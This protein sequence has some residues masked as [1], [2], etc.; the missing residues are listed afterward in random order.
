VSFHFAHK[1]ISK[2]NDISDSQKDATSAPSH[3][4]YIERL[5][6]V[7]TTSD[8]LSNTAAEAGLVGGR[9][10]D[11]AGGF[12]YPGLFYEVGRESFG[13]LG[14]NK[15][16]RKNFWRLVETSEGRTA[17]VQN[18]IIA[19]LPHE[20]SDRER[21]QIS[22]KFCAK[23]AEYSLPFWATI[24]SPTKSNDKRNF[25]LHIAYYDRPSSRRKDGLWDFSIL[26]ERIKPNRSRVTVRPFKQNK[27]N[28][29]RSRDWVKGLRSHFAEVNNEILEAGGHSKRLDPRSYR[30][31]GIKKTPTEHLGF[32]SNAWEKFGLE[33]T[34]GHRN[35]R[36][37]YH[38][39]IFDARSRWDDLIA[40]HDV[41]LLFEDFSDNDDAWLSQKEKKERMNEGRTAAIEATKYDLLSEAVSSRVSTRKSFLDQ[42]RVRLSTNQKRRTSPDSQQ[43]ITLI[44]IEVGVINN[45]L[46]DLLTTASLIS[47]KAKDLKKIEDQI[48]RE[49]SAPTSPTNSEFD[50][51]IFDNI[52]NYPIDSDVFE[53]TRPT[54]IEVP[55]A[56]EPVDALLAVNIEH[57]DPPMNADPSGGKTVPPKDDEPSIPGSFLVGDLNSREDLSRLNDTLLAMTN[58][59]VRVRAI[60]SRDA[61]E[62]LEHGE[63]RR[64]A[65]RGWFILRSEAEQRGVNLETGEQS[66]SHA[67]NKER[68][69]LHTDQGNQSVLEIREEVIRIM[70]R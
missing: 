45:R 66:I 30:E 70:S 7:D 15:A 65:K 34:R 26:E 13:T 37:E 20:V 57:E 62:L 68:A 12:S 43:G 23:L 35:S 11:D 63:E 1:T 44:D 31:S 60:A 46:P 32:K 53:S 56:T 42:E 5:E 9:S 50:Y 10:R 16:D 25:H 67:T 39:R 6:A 69:R 49:M 28:E 52:P 38:W 40:E 54:G 19:E 18:R 4:G 61:S 22:M 3:Q 55:P 27:S 33:T 58:R 64:Q 29:V 51:S 17:R 14:E 47:D 36:K 21:R 24:H 2:R 41:D 8:D 48:W 59:E